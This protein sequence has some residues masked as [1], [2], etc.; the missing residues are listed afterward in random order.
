MHIDTLHELIDGIRQRSAG[1]GK[2]VA[3]VNPDDM[4]NEIKDRILI[5]EKLDSVA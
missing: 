3:P 1:N 2:K 4:F 5:K